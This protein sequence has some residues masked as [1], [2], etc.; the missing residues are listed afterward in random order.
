[1]VSERAD[2]IG[3]S[4]TLKM[5]AKV[6]AMKKGGIDVIDLSIG[7]PDFP[8]PDNIKSAAKSAIDNN[9]TKYT[10]SSGIPELKE[11]IIRKLKE[12]NGLDYKP[13][14]IVVSNGAK[15]SIYNVCMSLIDRGE[16]V[17]V[18][19]PFWVSYPEMVSLAEGRVLIVPTKEEDG[20]KLTPRAL[21]S[22]ITPKTRAV[23]LNN[24]SNPTGAA[25]SRDEL[26]A[27]GK[28][29]MEENIYVI[30]DEI[31]EKLVYDDFKFISFAALSPEIMEKTIIVNGVS[32]AYSMTGWRIGF[33][34][35]P[36]DVMN[37]VSKIQS[38][39]TSNPGSVSQ[40]ASLEA[41][42]GPQFEITRMVS[43]FQ[44]RR[45]FI[46][47]KLRSIPGVSVNT[48]EGAFYVEATL[49]FDQVRQAETGEQRLGFIGSWLE[50]SLLFRQPL[51][52]PAFVPYPLLDQRPRGA[53]ESDDHLDRL[54]TSGDD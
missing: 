30:A 16:E 52:P 42:N 47:H 19:A 2:Y 15:H 14:Q 13:N 46:L 39:S 20:F 44:K 41:F 33:A 50:E 34:A 12:E 18:P 40:M 17:I 10:P 7:E 49:E 38:H 45:N 51:Q 5:A 54:A 23:I 37:G 53:G 1:M 43:E 27:L 9:I 22:A 6:K 4:A 36:L 48:P 3:E 32:K 8:T 24:P 21:S 26:E 28:V 11:A 31:Y 29:V 25:Y 35:G